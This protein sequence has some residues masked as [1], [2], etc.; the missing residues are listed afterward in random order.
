MYIHIIR[1]EHF[2]PVIKLFSQLCHLCCSSRKSENAFFLQ[3]CQK[4]NISNE[5]GSNEMFEVVKV[6]S[7]VD[8]YLHYLENHCKNSNYVSH[9]NN[10][11]GKIE[12]KKYKKQTKLTHKIDGNVN[13]LRY[14]QSIIIPLHQC[15]Q[16]Y[17]EYFSVSYKITIYIL[18]INEPVIFLG[19]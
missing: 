9:Q 3:T 12:K 18:E 1:E 19:I 5:K 14:F 7:S 2:L 16:R 10:H 11:T 13:K 6:R 4:K 17:T 8:N 15:F